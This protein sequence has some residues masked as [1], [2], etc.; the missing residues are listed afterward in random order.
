VLPVALGIAALALYV[1]V[2]GGARVPVA[3]GPPLDDIDATSR[4]RLEQVIRDAERP[5]E[6]AR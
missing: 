2:T 5:E 4:A 3:T 6:V 1:L